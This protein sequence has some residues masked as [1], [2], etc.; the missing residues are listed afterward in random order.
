MKAFL[1]K[2][3]GTLLALLVLF[4]SL[5]FT[6]DRHYCGDHL[7]DTSYFGKADTCAAEKVKE[8]N[9]NKTTI[10]K[11]SCC[12]DVT[13]FIEAPNFEK[14]ELVK[15]TQKQIDFT[16]AF[17]YSYINIYKETQLEKEFYKDFSPPDF[18]KDFQ[19]LHQVFLI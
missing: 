14:K 9:L 18:Q 5:S 8:V 7:V 4:S 3:G 13:E 10:K 2:I 1:Q 16:I 6:V 17:V 12:K 19:V 11:K 15:I